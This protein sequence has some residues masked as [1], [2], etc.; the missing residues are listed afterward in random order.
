M[1]ENWKWS[2]DALWRLCDVF[3]VDQSSFVATFANMKTGLKC[4]S[5]YLIVLLFVILGL[6]S[7]TSNGKR[8]QIEEIAKRQLDTLLQTEDYLAVFW[9]KFRSGFCWIEKITFESMYCPRVARLFCLR[10]KFHQD[11]YCIAGRKIFF[12]L[13]FLKF[14]R[15][16]II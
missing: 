9:R 5:H 6:F 7:S 12:S 10:A 15:I 16:G 4:C 8:Q 13:F 2:R 11:M 3:C 14:D 1:D